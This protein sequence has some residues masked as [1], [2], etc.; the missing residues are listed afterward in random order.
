MK[1]FTN[2]NCDFEGQRL[3]KFLS[4]IFDKFSRSQIQKFIENGK[5]FVNDKSL[6]SSYVLRKDD[7]IS[8][9][10]L[11]QE[12]QVIKKKKTNLEV[13][14]E[15]ENVIAINKPAG[16]IVH[17]LEGGKYNGES[18]VNALVHKIDKGVGQTLRPGIVHRLDRDTS[19]I[20]FVAKT[21]KGYNSLISQ[22]K[23]RT[24]GKSYQA[25]VVGRFK[26]KE[27]IIDA[28]IGRAPSKRLRMRVY[29]GLGAKE[30]IS[31]YKVLEEYSFGKYDFSL[32]DVQIKTGRTHQ[33]RV[34]MAAISH[35]VVG[36]N[37][38]GN[39]DVNSLFVRKLELFRQ[40]LHAYKAS[41]VPV[42]GKK[43]VVITTK[44]PRDLEGVLK[45]LNKS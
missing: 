25:L 2:K 10:E 37:I 13:L 20:L 27:G 35:P 21:K 6:K 9:K 22:F 19:G 39:K 3:D 8:V 24:I 15:D 36:D 32:V 7:K 17:P 11:V 38:Y 26:D 34:H 43:E 41:F 4:S 28:P 16:L 33:I 40:F 23:K 31:Q 18:V 14:Y 44:L 42:A 1:I 12:K 30:A 5:V 29:E 45:N